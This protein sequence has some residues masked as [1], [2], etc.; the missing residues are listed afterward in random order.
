MNWTTAHQIAGEICDLLH[1]AGVPTTAKQHEQMAMIIQ[2][3]D[4]HT[5]NDHRQEWKPETAEVISA[6]ELK[7]LRGLQSKS[8]EWFE[9]ATYGPNDSV[10]ARHK[11]WEYVAKMK[12][13]K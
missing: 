8:F 13:G 12:A 6:E 2:K 10:K 4:G 9:Q 5:F 11:L 3:R 1:A 7:A